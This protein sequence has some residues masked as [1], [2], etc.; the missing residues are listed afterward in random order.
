MGEI[1]G[2]MFHRVLLNSRLKESVADDTGRYRALQDPDNWGRLAHDLAGQAFRWL[3][4]TF[5]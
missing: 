3:S 5:R 1:A 2:L 4:T